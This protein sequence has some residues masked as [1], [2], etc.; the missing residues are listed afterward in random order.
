MKRNVLIIWIIAIVLGNFI[1]Q[2]ILLSQL[3]INHSK[4]HFNT[5]ANIL[6]SN[7]DNQICLDNSVLASLASDNYAI[8]IGSGVI[9]GINLVVSVIIGLNLAN[10]PF[11]DEDQKE[12]LR[13]DTRMKIFTLIADN[14][15]IHLREICRLLNKKMGVIQYHI[16][17]LENCGLISSIKEGRYRRFFTNKISLRNHSNK[18]IMSFIKRETTSKLLYCIYNHN[19]TGIFHKELAGKVGITSQAI[20]WHIKK[21][22]NENII[23]A[24]KVGRQKKYFIV[25]E[26]LDILKNIIEQT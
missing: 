23:R 12:N 7:I 14:E 18:I 2:I 21:L 11:M 10:Y 16:Q 17:V 8:Q 19:G 22:L 4:F 6:R 3:T 20:T 25:D 5:P 15:G 26:Y 13:Q 9:G 1:P 24:E